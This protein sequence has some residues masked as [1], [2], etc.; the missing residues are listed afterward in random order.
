MANATMKN[1]VCNPTAKS[2]TETFNF[3]N[4]RVRIDGKV[5]AVDGTIEIDVSALVEDMAW[6]AAR[7]KNR[8]ASKAEGAICC[9]VTAERAQ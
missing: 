9:Q 5:V 6:R 8:K 1:T 4:F 7:N 3:R 2:K